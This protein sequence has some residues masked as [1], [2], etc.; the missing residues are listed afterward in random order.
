MFE[1]LGI[2]SAQGVITEFAGKYGLEQ[3]QSQPGKAERLAIW[4]YNGME[5]VQRH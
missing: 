2:S 4:R 1:K 5:D 3:V